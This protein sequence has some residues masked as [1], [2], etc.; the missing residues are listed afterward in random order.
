MLIETSEVF[1][2]LHLIYEFFGACPGVI[3]RCF[4]KTRYS[5]NPVSDPLGRKNFGGC[6]DGLPRGSQNLGF[7]SLFP[8]KI[9]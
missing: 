4:E 7:F 6:P 2:L 8:E 1:F 3:I 5:K 9:E